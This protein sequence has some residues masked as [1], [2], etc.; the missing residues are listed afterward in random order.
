MLRHPKTTARPHSFG[1]KLVRMMPRWEYYTNEAFRKAR[2]L[3]VSVISTSRQLLCSTSHNG[4]PG[5]ILPETSAFRRPIGSILQG[6]ATLK[7]S[8]RIAFMGKRGG[9]GSN[10]RDAKNPPDK[11]T[12]NALTRAYCSRLG[13]Q[14]QVYIPLSPMIPSVGGSSPF[15]TSSRQ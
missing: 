13:N 6:A 2:R 9:Y 14:Q 5:N 4:C 7:G 3:R 12:P 8:C 10:P 1:T 15:Y 11:C